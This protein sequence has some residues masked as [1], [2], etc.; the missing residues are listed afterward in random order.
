MT[1]SSSRRCR[2]KRRKKG[3]SATTTGEDLI[4]RALCGEAIR[5]ARILMAL[6]PGEPEVLGLLALML[7][8]YSRRAARTSPCGEI[9]LLEDQDR[10]RWHRADIEEGREILE[11]APRMRRPGSHQIQAAIAA[12][13]SEAAPG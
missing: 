2:R 11:R 6:V 1:R 8:Q 13:H 3:Y 7:V 12:I 4:R 10:A 5:L 9:V